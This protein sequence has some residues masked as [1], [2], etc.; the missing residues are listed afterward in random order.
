[1]RALDADHTTSLLAAFKEA[2]ELF[3][4]QKA[5]TTGNEGRVFVSLPDDGGQNKAAQVF[6]TTEAR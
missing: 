2:L 5:K 1:M 6:K 3:R 4:Q